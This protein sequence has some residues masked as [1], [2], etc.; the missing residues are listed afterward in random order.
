MRWPTILLADD[1][2]LEALQKLLGPKFKV[3]TSVPDG[4]TVLNVASE[5]KPDVIVLDVGL[6]LL[7]GVEAGSELKRIL[8]QTKLIVLS[9]TREIG[10][11]AVR[12]WASSYLL[13]N[14]A[15]SALIKA[16]RR[17]LPGR[18]RRVLTGRQRDVLRLLAEGRTMREAAEILDITPRT[19]AF[20]K[21]RIMEEFELK[22]NLDLI[23]FAIRERVIPVFQPPG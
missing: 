5:L 21:Y 19:I 2:T 6:R 1:H 8:P 9:M 11:E 18:S 13:K 20:H 16:I 7:S 22:N 10:R 17:V 3:V 4:Q 15:S 12:S 23:R 14:A